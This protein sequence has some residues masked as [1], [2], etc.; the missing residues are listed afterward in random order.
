MQIVSESLSL[1]LGLRN[2]GKSMVAVSSDTPSKY[3]NLGL[4]FTLYSTGS[5]LAC[6]GEAYVSGPSGS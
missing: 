3:D 1:Y 5:R 2:L 6:C 4:D